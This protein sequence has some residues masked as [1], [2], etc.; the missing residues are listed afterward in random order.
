MAWLAIKRVARAGSPDIP[1]GGVHY[2]RP[3]SWTPPSTLLPYRD[4]SAKYK[5]P[6]DFYFVRVPISHARS[7]LL[8]EADGGTKRAWFIDE[9]RLSPGELTRIT[10]G[11]QFDLSTGR[12]NTVLRHRRTDAE[13]GGR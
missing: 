8:L 6:G 12:A 1:K 11:A 13:F 2:V 4:F 10:P 9:A 7:R 5:Y 3:D